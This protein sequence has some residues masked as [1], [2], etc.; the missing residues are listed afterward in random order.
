[1]LQEA[2]MVEKVRLQQEMHI[3]AQSQGDTLVMHQHPM[4]EQ[5][6]RP[7]EQNLVSVISP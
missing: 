5:E 7:Q 6:S 1:M 4:I 3:L 2:E